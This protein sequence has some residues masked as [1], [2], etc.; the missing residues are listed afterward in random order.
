MNVKK[1][2]WTIFIFFIFSSYS[3]AYISLDGDPKSAPLPEEGSYELAYDEGYLDF[4][5]ELIDSAE[6]EPYEYMFLDACDAYQLVGN[7]PL[8]EMGYDY[9]EAYSNGYTS[10]ELDFEK[11][12]PEINTLQEAQENSISPEELESIL[13]QS[14]RDM[15]D[16]KN[17]SYQQG[18]DE[19]SAL[20]H[21][22]SDSDLLVPVILITIFSLAL[23]HEHLFQRK[24]KKKIQSLEAQ[25]SEYNEQ[26]KTLEQTFNSETTAMSDTLIALQNENT[27][28]NSALSRAMAELKNKNDR[29][30]ALQKENDRLQTLIKGKDSYIRDLTSKLSKS[31]ADLSALQ[32]PLP[33]RRSA[34]WDFSVHFDSEQLKRFLRAKTQPIKITE[35]HDAYVTIRGTTGKEYETSLT[36]CTCPDFIK[37]LRQR[38]PCKHIYFLALQMNIPIEKFF[39]DEDFQPPKSP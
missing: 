32:K 15:E 20:V 5:T 8:D 1:L 13:S 38:R 27:A 22:S 37:Q 14:Y 18:Y 24:L 25:L 9:D 4:F 33:F 3:Y 23:Y 10:A 16:A 17:K 2:W 31:Y 7:T 30:Q 19:A 28:L 12:L 21:D 26:N 39:P 29:S 36:S 6:Y 11:M 35:Y 34:L